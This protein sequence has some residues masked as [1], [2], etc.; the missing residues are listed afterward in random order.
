MSLPKQSEQQ[1]TFHDDDRRQVD[2]ARREAEAL[3]RP[4]SKVIEPSTLTSPPPTNSPARRPRILSV[5]VPSLGCNIVK[6]P[7]NAEPQIA[8]SV[9]QFVYTDRERLNRARATIFKQQHEL[10]IKLDATDSELRAIDAYEAAKKS[11]PSLGPAA[12]I[13]SPRMQAQ[14]KISQNEGRV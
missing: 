2:R 8:A 14:R 3:F 1:H 7:I 9:S 13:R 4:K 6:T 5:S 11:K 12:S 10:Q